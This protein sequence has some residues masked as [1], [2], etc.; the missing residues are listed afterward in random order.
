MGPPPPPI[1]TFALYKRLVCQCHL[2]TPIDHLRLSQTQHALLI[3]RGSRWL[4]EGIALYF[5]L[6][7]MGHS[8]S[9]QRVFCWLGLQLLGQ[10]VP[11]VV[12]QERWN[13]RETYDWHMCISVWSVLLEL[14]LDF[15]LITLVVFPTKRHNVS[16]KTPQQHPDKAPTCASSCASCSWVM[17]WRSSGS[18]G[19]CTVAGHCGWS[20]DVAGCRW[21]WTWCRTLDT[22]TPWGLSGS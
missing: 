3:C 10:F 17:T 7:V 8:A 16:T 14:Y 13:L 15:A 6:H 9:P 2:L 18:R 1:R 19:T 11:G 5:H 20:C 4:W 12:E 21:W 22:C